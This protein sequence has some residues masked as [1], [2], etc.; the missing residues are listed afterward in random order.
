M[1]SLCNYMVSDSIHT[2]ASSMS[3]I[4]V[5]SYRPKPCESK[6]VS[7]RI[8]HDIQSP[9]VTRNTMHRFGSW[10]VLRVCMWLRKTRPRT[11]LFNELNNRML[12]SETDSISCEGYFWKMSSTFILIFWIYEC[13]ALKIL[14]L[15]VTLDLI[16]TWRHSSS[17]IMIRWSRVIRELSSNF[18]D[19][20]V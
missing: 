1:N 13:F 8:L 10:I 2:M 11:C 18:K 16:S 7:G 17:Q 5:S 15:S 12:L 9:S 14:I 20:A 6:W 4:T 19:A 3:V